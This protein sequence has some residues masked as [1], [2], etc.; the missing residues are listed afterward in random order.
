MINTELKKEILSNTYN[1]LEK[2]KVSGFIC[3]ICKSGTGK[4]GT[5]IETKDNI[6][7]TCGKLQTRFNQIIREHNLFI[8]YSD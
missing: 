1:Y 6:H 4:N 7:F 3:P 2:A 5:G 8:K